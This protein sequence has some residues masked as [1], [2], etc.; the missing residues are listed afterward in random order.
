[1]T[2]VATALAVV[3]CA[4]WL[5]AGP[6]GAQYVT[7]PGQGPHVGGTDRGAQFTS[8]SAGHAASRGNSGVEVLGVR[9]V[10]GAN[11]EAIA[12]TGAGIS[13]LALLG[14][15]LVAAGVV[16]RRRSRHVGGAATA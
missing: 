2:K 5:V 4:L 10:R 9:F 15:G 3:F 13:T 16:I 14:F 7:P 12:L 11:G 6:A 8:H 1:M